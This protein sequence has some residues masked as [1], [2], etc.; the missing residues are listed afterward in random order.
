[1]IPKPSAK[2]SVQGALDAFYARYQDA[3]L[4]IEVNFRELGIVPAGGR[5]TH[6]IHPYPAKLLARIP[7]FFLGCTDLCVP[8]EM[9]LDPFCG[10]GTVLLEGQLSGMRV[11]GADSNPLAR[12]ITTAKLTPIDIVQA[13]LDLDAV[14]RS[15][16]TAQVNIPDVVNRSHWYSERTSEMLGRLRTAIAASTSPGSRA[17]FDVC[18]SA[19]ARRVSF[20]DP[21]L[22]VPVRI[23]PD[24]SERYGA[25]GDE[26]LRKLIW[27]ETID[28]NAVYWSIASQNIKRIA[29]TQSLFPLRSAQIEISENAMS[30]ALP[31]GSVDLVITSPPYVGAQKYIRASSLSLGWLGLTPNAALRPYEKRSIGREHLAK[32]ETLLEDVVVGAADDIIRAVA[33]VNVLR[34]R[35]AQ[36]YLI[37]MRTALQEIARVLKHGGHLVLVAGPNLVAGHCFDTPAYLKTLAEDAGL[38]TRLHLLDTIHSRG[39]M[40]KRN[41]TAGIIQQ[42]SVLVMAK[43]G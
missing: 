14:M 28:V 9:L 26:V 42:E 27:L 13:R 34:A 12:L 35:I 30:M 11:A 38:T 43:C 33:D 8:G 15:A 19:T 2:A 6:L 24:R 3:E 10:S 37:E 23:N 21:R 25:R 17:L 18:F 16:P 31:D 5:T 32:D 39:L 20:A 7:Q 36:R 40:T 22:S 4:P 41:R 29:E 1:M